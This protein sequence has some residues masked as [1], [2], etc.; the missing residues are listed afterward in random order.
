MKEAIKN[1]RSISKLNI[2]ELECV[3]K[4]DTTTEEDFYLKLN[5]I[6]SEMIKLP[7]KW[8]RLENF[9]SINKNIKITFIY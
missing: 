7:I 9:A 8:E 6:D 5:N 3:I 2:T 4:I 1:L